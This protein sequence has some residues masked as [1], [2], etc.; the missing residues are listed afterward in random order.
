ML[1]QKRPVVEFT[2]PNPRIAQMFPPVPAGRALPDWWR[3]TP[4][5]VGPEKRRFPNL[6]LRRDCTVKSC[7]GIYDFLN[8][9]W[10]LPLWADLVVGAGENGFKCESASAATELGS[11]VPDE[12][13]AGFPRRQGDHNYVLKL[14][15]PWQVR[16]SKGWSLLVLPPLYHGEVAWQVMAGIIDSDRLPV[17]NAIIEWRAPLEQ[18][19]L[20]KAGTPLMHLIPFQRQEVPLLEVH[21][22]NPKEWDNSFGP[23]I[24]G[25]EGAR[26]A[27]GAYRDGARAQNS[28]AKM[29]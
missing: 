14:M 10:I 18:P 25:I 16:A 24:N 7:P 13:G 21:P 20:L 29:A 1:R 27:A 15:T 28:P 19:E 5:F 17:L 12:L 23:G 8:R 9:G 6:R 4:A 3:K 22:V 26:L 11:F 2:T